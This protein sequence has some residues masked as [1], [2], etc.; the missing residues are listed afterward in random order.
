MKMEFEHFLFK[1]EIFFLSDFQY[2]K[3]NMV[4][5]WQYLNKRYTDIQL[6]I[7]DD[8]R[9]RKAVALKKYI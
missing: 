1:I 7:V 2:F 4:A 6:Q 3:Q 8:S 9:N 5:T